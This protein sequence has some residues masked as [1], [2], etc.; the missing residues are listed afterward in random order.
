MTS[1]CLF[2]NV[3]MKLQPSSSHTLFLAL[4]ASREE[5]FSLTF[6]WEKYYSLKSTHAI[7]IQT[8][9][10]HLRYLRRHYKSQPG[11]SCYSKKSKYFIIKCL[12][13]VLVGNNVSILGLFSTQL[14]HVYAYFSVNFCLSFG[15]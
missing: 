12:F 10:G 5:P 13:V 4:F 11:N 1:V 8:N 2:A 14:L 9:N 6:D 15:Q 7:E 3:G